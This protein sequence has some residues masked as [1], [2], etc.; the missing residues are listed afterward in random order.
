MIDKKNIYVID[1]DPI[2]KLITR[3]ILEKQ[4]KFSNVLF[5]ENGLEGLTALKDVIRSGKGTIPGTIFL[6]IEMPVMGGWNFMDE[7]VKI[8]LEFR[9]GIDVY[10][11]SS[12]IADDDKQRA[13]NYYEIKEYITKPLTTEALNRITNI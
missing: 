4:G 2:F 10:I 5:F 6:D 13:A 12:S 3:K 1:D 9:K 8:P 7:F 11:V